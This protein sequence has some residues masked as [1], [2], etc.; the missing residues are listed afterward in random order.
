MGVILLVD[1]MPLYTTVEEAISWAKSNGL[2][3]YHTHAFENITG[4]MGGENHKVAMQTT[5]TTPQAKKVWQNIDGKCYC[6]GTLMSNPGCHGANCRTCCYNLGKSAF[7]D[8]DQL[9]QVPITPPVPPVT[10]TGED[11]DI[12]LT[13]ITTPPTSGGGGY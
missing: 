7:G 11:E 13:T 5:T 8:P 6:Y 2:S 9:S 10:T 4:Y 12:P 1:N 3:G